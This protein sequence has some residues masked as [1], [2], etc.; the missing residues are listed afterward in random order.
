MNTHPKKN[1]ATSRRILLIVLNTTKNMSRLGHFTLDRWIMGKERLKS[2][3]IDM[4]TVV[5]LKVS[6]DFRNIT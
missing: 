4:R 3:K 2:G 6:R 1:R 5:D